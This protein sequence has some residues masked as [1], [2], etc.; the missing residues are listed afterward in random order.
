MREKKSFSWYDFSRILSFN[1][2]FMMVVGGRGLGKTYGAKKY[3]IKNYLKRGEQFIYLRRFQKEMGAKNTFFADIASEFP[4]CGFKING[5]EALITRNPNDEKPSY[6]VIGYFVCLSVAQSKKSVSYPLVT[7]IIF[8]EFILE[9]GFNRYMDNEDEVFI[10]FYNTVDRWQDK[11]K[12]FFLANSVSIM[13]PYFIAWDIDPVQEWVHYKNF[14]VAHFPD[15]KQ[16]AQEVMSTRIGKFIEGTNYAKYAVQNDFRDNANYLIGKKS[17]T[18]SYFFTMETTTINFSVWVD[19]ASSPWTYYVQSKSP[20]NQ[21]IWVMDKE[22]MAEGKRL[23]PFNDDRLSGLRPAY[24]YGN[25]LFESSRL[26]NSFLR[27][28]KR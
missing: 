3:A 18:S 16:F 15:S 21:N 4:E 12:V 5:N 17:E 13:N 27:I 24:G 28:F 19:F 10:N 25:V 9:R 14:V 8:D 22:L 1:A 20:G 26:R 23:V 7:T 6:E 2:V 11:T